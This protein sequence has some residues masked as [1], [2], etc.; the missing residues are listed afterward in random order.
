M[1]YHHI[2]T[3]KDVKSRA[4][5]A[6]AAFMVK[7]ISGQQRISSQELNWLF[8]IQIS[9]LF[10][11]ADVTHGG[12]QRLYRRQRL[13]SSPSRGISQTP[14]GER[15]SRMKSCGSGQASTCGKADNAK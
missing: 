7:N 4:R 1:M 15:E 9:D 6:R 11:Y 10:Y 12:Q 3:D 8:S 14:G 5:K 13:S 2:C